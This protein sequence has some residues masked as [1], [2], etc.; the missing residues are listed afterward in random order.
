MPITP[1][2]VVDPAAPDQVAEDIQPT[3][4]PDR[5]G[6]DTQPTEDPDHVPLREDHEDV[7]DLGKFMP[8]RD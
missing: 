6:G 1:K 8:E 7:A 3:Q 2:P 5:A 4:D